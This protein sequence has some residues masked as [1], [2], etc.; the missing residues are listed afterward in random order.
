MFI[1]PHMMGS[2]PIESSCKGLRQGSTPDAQ[3]L[4]IRADKGVFL[5]LAPVIDFP[6]FMLLHKAESQIQRSSLFCHC[7]ADSACP[8]V[9]L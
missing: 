4:Q 7:S 3:R 5:V 6:L 2:D 9:Q 8:A 1:I